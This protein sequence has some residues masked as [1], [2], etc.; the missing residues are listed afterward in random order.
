MRSD[1]DQRR[2]PLPQERN[3]S[4]SVGQALESS[5]TESELLMASFAF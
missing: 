5:S 3:E 4:V 2:H 1:H